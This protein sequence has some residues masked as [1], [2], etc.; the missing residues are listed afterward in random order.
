MKNVLAPSKL[1]L[2]NLLRQLMPWY[3]KRDVSKFE[4]ERVFCITGSLSSKYN[5]Y[6]AEF[7]QFAST[8]AFPK[9]SSV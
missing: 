4:M 5:H 7:I 2:L 1:E 9:V 8:E 3:L 6:L